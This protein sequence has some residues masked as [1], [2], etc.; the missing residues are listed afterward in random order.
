MRTRE[1]IPDDVWAIFMEAN[2]NVAQL[3]RVEQ[4]SQ[5]LV[6][7]QIFETRRLAD[8]IEA[9]AQTTTTRKLYAA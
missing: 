9:L 8:A 7:W 3:D 4:S 2:G 6:S 1:K 5:L